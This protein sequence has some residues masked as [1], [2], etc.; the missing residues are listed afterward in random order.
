M[1][2][3][4]TGGTPPNRP[5]L[6]IF[7]PEAQCS[8]MPIPQNELTIRELVFA[9]LDHSDKKGVHG[10]KAL[11]ERYQTLA[12]IVLYRD[13]RTKAR[14]KKQSEFSG[15]IDAPMPDGRIVGDCAPS[16]VAPHILEDWIEN[17]GRWKSSST[18]KAKANQINA[19]FN[20]AVKG[21]RIKDNPF[22]GITY[23]EAEKRVP[24]VDD[25]LEEL[26]QV[27]NKSFDELAWYLRLVGRRLGEVCD[28]DWENI[29]WKKM[30][31][32]VV[33]FKGRKRIRKDQYYALIPKAVDLLER[34]RRR[35][36]GP[37]TGA[38][39]LNSHGTRW[40]PGNAGQYFRRLRARHSLK[41][42]GTIHGIRH[43][44]VSEMIR[45]GG[46]IKAASLQAGHAST[47]ITEKFYCHM[48]EAFEDMR[49]AAVR[50]TEAED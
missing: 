13:R 49:K 39:F 6:G 46:N 8:D 50:G 42:Q 7:D 17:N 27:A 40:T 31:V 25:F 9:Y 37:V 12:G 22:S 2:S 34:I 30:T 35:V 33:K 19:L 3:K 24:L 29:D 16:Q 1:Q 44:A 14:A 20:W 23:E 28:M 36:V 18:R 4:S 11:V 15:F 26:T 48:E 5:F 21:K 32:R 43:H 45:K 38:V 10:F 47:T 41:G